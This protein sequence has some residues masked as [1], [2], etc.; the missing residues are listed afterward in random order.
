[1][2]KF[3]S[4]LLA[5]LVAWPCLAN[6]PS[7]VLDKEL[8]LGGISLGDAEVAVLGKLGKPSRISDTGESIRLDYPGL[9]I[10]L[11]ESRRV[12]E[13]LST[14]SQYCS[15]AGVCPGQS[16]VTARAKYGRPLVANR[17]DG[18]FMEYPSSQSSCWLQLAV[19]RS[20]VESVRA[21]CQ[22]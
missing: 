5:M 19:Y 17:E 10:W 11:G 8:S 16:F 22:P 12:G 3:L 6:G 2:S 4:V 20:V 13:I 18:R 15:P 1:M 14:N 21:E 7:S 9:T